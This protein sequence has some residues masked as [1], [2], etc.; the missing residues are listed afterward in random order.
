MTNRYKVI[1]T[2]TEREQLTEQTRGGKSKA[3]KFVYARALL[4]CDAGEYGDPWT[5]ADAALALGVTNHTMEHLNVEEGL[6]AVPARKA[7]RK[8]RGATFDGAL[9]PA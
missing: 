6:E 5:V 9:T 3:A 2:K 7:Y 4:L 1:L 8:P